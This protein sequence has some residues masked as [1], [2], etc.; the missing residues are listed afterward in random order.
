MSEYEEPRSLNSA[1]VSKLTLNSTTSRIAPLIPTQGGKGGDG[2]WVE[3]EAQKA[4]TILTAEVSICP[5]CVL[6]ITFYFIFS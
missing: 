5:S 6:L 2:V 3:I 1:H 4:V